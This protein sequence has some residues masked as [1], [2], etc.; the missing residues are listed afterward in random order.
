MNEI[1]LAYKSFAVRVVEDD[2][3]I[4]QT[5]LYAKLILETVI[6]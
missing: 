6:S 4:L 1:N 5:D 2:V 3:Y